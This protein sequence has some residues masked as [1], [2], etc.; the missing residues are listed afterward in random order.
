MLVLFSHPVMAVVTVMTN[1]IALALGLQIPTAQNAAWSVTMLV[2]HQFQVS[3]LLTAA[4]ALVV[5]VLSVMTAAAKHF[6]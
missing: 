5:V 4:L 2:Y 6:T 1:V 3:H